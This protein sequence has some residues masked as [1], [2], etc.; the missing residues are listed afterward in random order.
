MIKEG[1]GVVDFG[2]GRIRGRLAGDFNAPALKKNRALARRRGFYTP[3]PGGTG[4]IAVAKLFE[5]FYRLAA[6]QKKR[7]V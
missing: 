3:T 4:P 7:R 6:E 1:A 5:N 2:Y